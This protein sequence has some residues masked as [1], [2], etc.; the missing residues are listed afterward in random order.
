MAIV[1][2]I[3]MFQPDAA[4]ATVYKWTDDKGIVHY[5]DQM[6]PEAVNKGNVQLGPQGMPI[7]KVAPAIAPEQHKARAAESEQ[8]R[9][10]VKEQQAAA[11]RDRALLDS[12]TEESDIDLARRRATKTLQAALESAQGYTT[13]L[14]KRKVA[15]AEKR[16]SY[17]GKAVPADIE[18]ELAA[19]DGELDRQSTVIAQKNRQL[20]E[21]AAKYDAEKERWRAIKS[22]DA[23]KPS[24]AQGAAAVAAPAPTPSPQPAPRK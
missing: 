14:T 24:P 19:I 18:Q 11:R 4:R 23:A 3:A 15:L 6:P 22:G 5:S 20:V 8:Q 12:Y 1:L 17:A 10:A 13:Q 2:A 16:A 21:V 7:R 9:E